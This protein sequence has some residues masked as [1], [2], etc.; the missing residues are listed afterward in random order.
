MSKISEDE[1]T[2]S[3]KTKECAIVLREDH[4]IDIIFPDDFHD[5]DEVPD[6]VLAF[7]GAAFALREKEWILKLHKLAIEKTNEIPQ[8]T[9]ETTEDFEVN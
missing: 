8:I 1:R 9:K 2:I 7:F 4:T 3:L 5:H 6:H